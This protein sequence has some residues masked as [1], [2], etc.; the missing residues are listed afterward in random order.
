MSE[1]DIL[2]DAEQCLI[3]HLG[4][5]RDDILY[6]RLIGRQ[7]LGRARERERRVREVGETQEDKEDDRIVEECVRVMEPLSVGEA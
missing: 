1:S 2:T 6:Q 7:K 3:R 4:E 5:S